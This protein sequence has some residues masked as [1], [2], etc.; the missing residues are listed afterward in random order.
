[1]SSQLGARSKVRLGVVSPRSNMS[2][3]AHSIYGGH[4]TFKWTL[5]A[6]LPISSGKIFFYHFSLFSEITCIASCCDIINCFHIYY[7]LCYILIYFNIIHTSI[8]FIYK[9]FFS[10]SLIS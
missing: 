7:L 3:V 10:L 5:E 2:T 4:K 9:F 6:D 8:F 1:M